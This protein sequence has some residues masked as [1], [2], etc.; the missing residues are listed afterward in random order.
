MSSGQANCILTQHS[1]YEPWWPVD[2]EQVYYINHITVISEGSSSEERN[3][4]PER[5][6]KQTSKQRNFD[7]GFS[8]DTVLSE[9]FQTLQGYNLAF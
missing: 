3:V 1:D 7:I 8:S 5:A 2:L 9:V 4:L 6:G